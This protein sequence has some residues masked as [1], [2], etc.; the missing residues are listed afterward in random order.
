MPKPWWDGGYSG[1]S[2]DEWIAL[3]EAYD[4]AS[5]LFPLEMAVEQKRDRVGSNGITVEELT[6]LAV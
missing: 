2:I 4:P 6:I 1:Q 3:G 5:L